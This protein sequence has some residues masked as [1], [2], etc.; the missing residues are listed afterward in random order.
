MHGLEI[1]GLREYV[2][3]PFAVAF[4]LFDIAYSCSVQ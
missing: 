3:A 2:G 1:V 4:A